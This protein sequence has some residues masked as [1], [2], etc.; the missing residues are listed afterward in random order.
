M[1]DFLIGMVM[2]P[3]VLVGLLWGLGSGGQ[4]P[5]GIETALGIRLG[6]DFFVGCGVGI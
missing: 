5:S 1:V 3:L 2:T 4:L 6:S